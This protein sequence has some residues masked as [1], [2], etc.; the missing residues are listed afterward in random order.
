MQKRGSS[1]VPEEEA[2][3]VGRANG[4][5][6]FVGVTSIEGVVGVGGVGLVGV[7]DSVRAGMRILND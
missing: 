6:G 2:G 3:G 4:I 1:G 5:A 7:V